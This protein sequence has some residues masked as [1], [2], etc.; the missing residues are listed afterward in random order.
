MRRGGHPIGRDA[1]VH[2]GVIYN[3]GVVYNRGAIINVSHLG[4]R[5]TG[6]LEVVTIKVMH[7]YKREVIGV[8]TEI[9][10]GAHPN[11]IKPPAQMGIKNGM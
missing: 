4:N 10:G 11:A 7:R 8:Q 1:T 5:K 9:K 3:R 2:D 6:S